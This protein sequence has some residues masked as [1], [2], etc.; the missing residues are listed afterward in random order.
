MRTVHRFILTLFYFFLFETIFCPQT[1]ATLPVFLFLL[2]SFSVMLG[3]YATP[4]VE[5]T[6]DWSEWSHVDDATITQDRGVKLQK[7]PY[8]PLV[9]NGL[10]HYDRNICYREIRNPKS[11]IKRSGR[12][13]HE[14][15]RIL[16]DAGQCI[17]FI[18]L[19]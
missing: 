11:C 3:R 2:S 17:L 14:P 19:N 13:A 16:C 9:R 8:V 6:G 12:N 10:S 18:T 15:E 1:K 7:F 5:M 4:Q